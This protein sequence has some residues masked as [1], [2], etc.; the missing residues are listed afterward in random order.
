MDKQRRISL[1]PNVAILIV[2]VGLVVVLLILALVVFKVGVSRIN[3]QREKLAS[4]RK[5]ETTLSQKRDVLQRVQ[6]EVSPYADLSIIAL[7]DKSPALM[8]ISQLKN[9][10]S[11]KLVVLTN[12]RVSSSIG[13]KKGISR[14]NVGFD[15]DGDFSQV[16]DFLKATSAI[17]PIS[18]LTK[19]EVSQ[20][21]GL[22]RASATL[23][24]FWVPLPTKLP[25]LTEA[26][27]ELTAE[28][29]ALI[30]ELSLL[31]PPSFVE[32][33]PTGASA[34]LDPFAI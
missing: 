33:A 21:A 26:A 7:P 8:I 10:A 24:S 29:L 32:V 6:G 28:E 34:R 20:S 3:S 30:S 23:I 22:T 5:D 11:A 9:L 25:P 4:T 12:L 19:V 16:T 27:G 31:E 13:E 2:P 17:A 15:V 18:R 1:P 14:I